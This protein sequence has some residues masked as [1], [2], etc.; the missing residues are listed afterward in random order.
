MTFLLTRLTI[1]LSAVLICAGWILSAIWGLNRLGYAIAFLMAAPFAGRWLTAEWQRLRP[2]S[3]HTFKRRIRRPLASAFLFLAG[4]TLVGGLLYAPDNYD[5]LAYRVPRTLNWLAEGRWHWIHTS[6]PR[7]NTRAQGC[8]WIMAP[9]VLFFRSERVMWAQNFLM[10]LAFPGL[11]F[12]TLR[13]AG[14]PRRVAWQ[15]MWIL[16][17][18]YCFVLQA[19]GISND[20]PGVFFAIAAVA[21]ALRARATGRRSDVWFSMLAAAL[22]SGLKASNAP[23]ALPWLVAVWPTLPLLRRQIA[24]TVLV[25]LVALLCS[26]LPG[27]ILN[28][29]YCG[30]WSGSRLEFGPVK[31]PPPWALVVGNTLGLVVQNLAPP[32]FPPAARWNAAVPTWL[33]AAYQQHVV[34]YFE[35]DQRGSGNLTLGELQM[36]ESAGLGC[37][38]TIMLVIALAVGL[39]GRREWR[40]NDFWTLALRWSPWVALVFFSSKMNVI[41]VARLASPYYP[42]VAAAFLAGRGQEWLSRRR[43]WQPL[44]IVHFA[45]ATLLVVVSPPRPLWPALTVLNPLTTR[46]PDSASIQRVRTVYSVYRQRPDVMAPIRSA[47]PA[48][49][50]LVGLVTFDDLETSL[51]RPFI[52][53]RFVHVT[54]ADTSADLETRGIHWLVIGSEAFHNQMGGSLADWLLR[55]NAE[56]VATIPVQARAGHAALDWY[57]AVRRGPAVPP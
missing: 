31:S 27:A 55:M 3:W 52:T 18:G 57:V 23:L 10:F 1:L 21:L 39:G 16:P 47:L 36:E 34:P 48:E 2:V 32:V 11:L 35:A 24:A 13:G 53:R 44:A 22:I 7:M 50:T 40:R 26:F 29:R 38:A 20:L 6:F 37:T 8:E 25:A 4:L 45:A 15:W 14:V 42:L 19:G 41:A 49:A 30:D 56:L 17:C 46:H 28:V 5:A 12:T 51:W 33:P 54:R 9:V 43:W